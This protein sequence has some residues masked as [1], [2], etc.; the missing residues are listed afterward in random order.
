MRN[1]KSCFLWEK[2]KKKIKMSFAAVVISPV[3]L[4]GITC[5]T[6][7]KFSRWKIDDIFGIFPRKQDLTF[8][9]DCLHWWQFAWNVKSSFEKIRKILKNVICWKFFPRMLSIKLLDLDSSRQH[10]GA[11][12]FLGSYWRVPYYSHTICLSTCLSIHLSAHPLISSP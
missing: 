9:A 10:F 1:V 7:D 11:L 3:R 2:K 5:T 12:R 4:Q 8:Y 6:L